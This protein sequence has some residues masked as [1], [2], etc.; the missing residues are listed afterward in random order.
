VC[1]SGLALAARRPPLAGAS[2][3]VQPTGNSGALVIIR[4]TRGISWLWCYDRSRFIVPPRAACRQALYS[5]PQTAKPRSAPPPLDGPR[6]RTRARR[7]PGGRPA[8]HSRTKE[9]RAGRPQGAL[10]G[11]AHHGRPRGCVGPLL[12][13]G[14]APR[15]PV[16]SPNYIIPDYMEPSQS[17]LSRLCSLCTPGSGHRGSRRAAPRA[18]GP[19]PRLQCRALLQTRRGRMRAPGAEGQVSR[20]GA[21]PRARLRRCRR[22]SAPRLR[23]S[24][25]A[26]RGARLPPRPPHAL[27]A[28]PHSTFFNI[29]SAACSSPFRAALGCRRRGSPY[30]AR[31]DSPC[32]CDSME[33]RR[34]PLDNS[35]PASKAHLL[36][37]ECFTLHTTT[38]PPL[39][40]PYHIHALIHKRARGRAANYVQ[41][42]PRLQSSTAARPCPDACK[43]QRCW[44]QK[45][46]ARADPVTNKR[47][48]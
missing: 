14:R 24:P 22:C 15:H 21:C 2:P 1:R 7:P 34:A 36:H 10:I 37:R 48:V 20:A 38:S 31:Q 44:P 39:D 16:P 33:S 28:R 40:A 46:M 23:P 6:G 43:E 5:H 27:F 47:Q 12:W 25:P 29:C 45:Q 17:V 19:A 11:R 18:A 35:R 13:H 4:I 30:W 9:L 42:S 32:C 41:A 8:G 3:A 26:G